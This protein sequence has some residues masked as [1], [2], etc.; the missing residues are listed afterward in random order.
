MLR[1][2]PQTIAPDVLV[3][4]AV[5]VAREALGASGPRIEARHDA[6]TCLLTVDAARVERAIGN[7]MVKAARHGASDEPVVVRTRADAAGAEI[8]IARAGG[9]LDGHAL[10]AMPRS[11][12]DSVHPLDLQTALARQLVELQGGSIVLRAASGA[13][14]PSVV[15]RLPARAVRRQPGATRDARPPVSLRHRLDGVHVLLVEDDPDALDFLSLI[16]AQAGATVS[17][18][19]LAGP[20]FDFFARADAAAD[21]VVSDIAMPLEDGYSLLRRLRALELE[22]R[23]VPVPAVAVSAFRRDED[24]RRAVAHGF[25]GHIAKPVDA[26]QL[27]DVIASWTRPGH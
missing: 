14:P 27:V 16:L 18:F 3:E 8:R 21:I 7:L 15:V 24:V 13:I 4:R 23:R 9:G 2:E 6:H 1:A 12:G 26:S 22:Q 10:G 20:A 25:D 19:P 11:A 5:A 17:P